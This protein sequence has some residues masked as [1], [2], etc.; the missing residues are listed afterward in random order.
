MLTIDQVAVLKHLIENEPEFLESSA[1]E[2]GVSNPDASIGVAKLLVA[3]SE[4][5]QRLSSKQLFHYETVIEPLIHQVCCDGMVGDHE[6]GSSSCVGD[7]YVDEVSL[8]RGY[9]L[10]DMRCQH[11]IA[12]ADS[13]FANNP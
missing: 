10:E 9:L 1:L 11:C 7:G 3:S 8:L 13:W 6:D 5:F 12:T 2:G 4:N